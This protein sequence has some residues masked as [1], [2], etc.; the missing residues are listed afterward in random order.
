MDNVSVVKRM[1]LLAMLASISSVIKIIFQA[2]TGPAARLTFYELPLII[3]GSVF[4]PIYGMLAGFIS[5]IGYMTT[6]GYGFS[7]MTISAMMWG[8]VSGVVL[9]K[10]T[11]TLKRII[12]VVIIAST[13]EFFING[14]QLF[15]WNS[16]ANPNLTF[17]MFMISSTVRSVILVAKWP[18]QIYLMHLIYTRVMD[19]SPLV[20][21]KQKSVYPLSAD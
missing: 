3:A 20:F 12:I 2:T 16:G 8:A 21:V 13:L 17:Q 9:Y 1:T 19:A 11:I 18:L 7:L 5:D 4:G 14:L 6:Y 15:I 10:R